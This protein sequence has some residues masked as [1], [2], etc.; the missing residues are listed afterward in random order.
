MEIKKEYLI[1]IG[2]LKKDMVSPLNE[3]EV[4]TE[5]SKEFLSLGIEGFN[6]SLGFGF[7]KGKPEKCLNISFINT[8]N[9]SEDSLIKSLGI[10]R[11]KLNQDSILLQSRNTEFNFI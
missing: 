10:L 4:L 6:S 11:E 9:I 7:W 8:F 5:V 1:N 3:N 2:L